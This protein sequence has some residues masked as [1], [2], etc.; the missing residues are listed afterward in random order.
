M[1]SLPL[2]RK[3]ALWVTCRW[4]T[5][6]NNNILC[7]LCWKNNKLQFFNTLAT[8]STKLEDLSYLDGQRNAPLRT[9]IRLPWHSTAGGRVQQEGEAEMFPC[10]W[11]SHTFPQLQ[12]GARLGCGLWAAL[13]AVWPCS[14]S[15][16]SLCVSAT[17]FLLTLSPALCWGLGMECVCLLQPVTIK[18]RKI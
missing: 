16:R 8:S 2:P 13:A 4:R 11:H 12:S 6:I 10:M 7:N 9:S 1:T 18:G 3:T 17:R 14:A 15:A 5:V